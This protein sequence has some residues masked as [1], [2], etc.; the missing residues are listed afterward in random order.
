[1][2]FWHPTALVELPMF[3]AVCAVPLASG[4]VV[5]VL[6]PHG[7][8]IAGECPELFR[9]LVVEFLGPFPC[10]KLLYR[11]PAGEELVAISPRGVL[12]VGLSN[13]R[14]QLACPRRV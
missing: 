11:L 10:Q 3:V 9:Q 14:A 12:C 13:A 4:I 5:L 2:T 1:M 6:K 7:D 8:A